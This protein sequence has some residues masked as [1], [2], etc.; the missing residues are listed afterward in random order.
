[1]AIYSMGKLQES[2]VQTATTSRDAAVV[3]A[4]TI[5]APRLA[6][7]LDVMWNQPTGDSAP[8]EDDIPYVTPSAEI[9][10][11]GLPSRVL[12]FYPESALRDLLREGFCAEELL[13]CAVRN[14]PPAPWMRGR[15]EQ[16][17]PTR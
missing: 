8:N 4:A 9:S 1:M 12:S 2:S 7:A 14:D 5:R 11:S 15:E 16:R 13:T 3:Q 17:K 6:H 10:L